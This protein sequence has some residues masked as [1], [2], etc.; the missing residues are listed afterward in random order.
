M[1]KQNYKEMEK[2]PYTKSEI[3]IQIAANIKPIH[4]KAFFPQET[5]NS[6]C[7]GQTSIYVSFIN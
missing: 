5:I 2:W 7:N 1:F 4:Q 6:T 3:S